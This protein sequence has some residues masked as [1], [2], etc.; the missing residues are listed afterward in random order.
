MESKL[1]IE[2]QIR[3]REVNGGKGEIQA[4]EIED[5]RFKGGNEFGD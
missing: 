1:R 5:V 4:E 2:V 3:G